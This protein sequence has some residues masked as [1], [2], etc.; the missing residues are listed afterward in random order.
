MTIT[1]G[2]RTAVFRDAH[3]SNGIEPY[4]GE[5]FTVTIE[6]EGLRAA[7]G[8]FVFSHDWAALT[9]FFADLAESWRGWDGT[10]EWRSIEGDLEIE[11]RSDPGR[12]C[13]LSFTVRNGPVYTWTA[14]VNDIS[15]DAGEDLASLAEAVRNWAAE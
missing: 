2:S 12:H 11:A 6:D 8:V 14:R 3:R 9:S 7:R 1:D 4:V 15:I 5:S 10:K 13:L